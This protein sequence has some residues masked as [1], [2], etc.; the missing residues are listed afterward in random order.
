[1][2]NLRYVGSYGMS[3]SGIIIGFRVW[4]LKAYNS[5][6]SFICEVSEKRDNNYL[7]YVDFINKL[8]ECGYKLTERQ[9][10]EM[11]NSDFMNRDW[12]PYAKRSDFVE[13]GKLAGF[14]ESDYI[15]VKNNKPEH[16]QRLF[17]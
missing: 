2:E 3:K 8:I 14:S 17:C 13:I 4:T 10:T 12:L 1:M 16:I 11:K 15:N 5:S 6:G 9:R 7:K